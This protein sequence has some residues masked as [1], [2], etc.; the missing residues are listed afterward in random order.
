MIS[1]SKKLVCIICLCLYSVFLG[2]CVSSKSDMRSFVRYNGSAEKIILNKVS[3][4]YLFGKSDVRSEIRNAPIWSNQRQTETTWNS[5]I[6]LEY[7]IRVAWHYASDP[8]QVNVA[9]FY[10]VDG[11]EGSRI[12]GSG[13]LILYFGL[14]NKWHLEWHPGTTHFTISE[15][16]TLA[17]SHYQ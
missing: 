13:A 1:Y 7:P 2:S 3:G 5:Q 15:L 17:E 6:L 10:H 12:S 14:D 9:T 8:S 11:A 16:K 4:I